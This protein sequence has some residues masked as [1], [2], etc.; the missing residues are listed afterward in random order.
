MPKDYVGHLPATDPLHPYLTEHILPQTG[1]DRHRA[2]FRVFSMKRSKV[3]LYEEKHSRTQFVGKFFADGKHNDAESSQRMLQEFDNLQFLRSYGLEGYPHH[4]VRPLGANDSLNSILVEEYCGGV[5]LSSVINAAIY[6]QQTQRLFSKLTALAYFLATLH[7]R[8]ANCRTVDFSQ[9]CSYLNQLVKKLRSQRS[10]EEREADELYWLRDRWSEKTRM[11]EDRQV[12]THGDATPSN[13]L[14]GEGLSV[15][16]IDLERMKR[17]DRV[18]DIG[19]IAGELQ[20]FFL[21]ATG[22]KLDA[23]P[24]IGHFLWE[25]ACHFPDRDRAFRSITA[26]LPFQ[27]GLT[28]LRIARNDWIEAPH[29][30]RLIQEAKIILRTV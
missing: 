22:N 9:D 28:L 30:R 5:S 15:I 10:I 14:F 17:A 25:Y 2:D 26:R 3:Y 20:H 23:E 8:T 1:G 6:H 29:R 19:R 18:F 7:N 21:Q 13:F 27:M 12:M 16:A 11:W 4:V 24:Y